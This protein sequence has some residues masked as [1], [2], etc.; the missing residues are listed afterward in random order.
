MPKPEILSMSTFAKEISRNRQRGWLSFD[1]QPAQLVCAPPPSP[2]DLA[3]ACGRIR[4]TIFTDEMLGVLKSWTD[5]RR[6]R[7]CRILDARS[8]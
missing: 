3:L 4:V 8:K 2:A 7:N 1:I 5:V 6:G